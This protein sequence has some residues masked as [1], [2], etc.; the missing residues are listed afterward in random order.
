ML[1][2]LRRA[3]VV[4]WQPPHLPCRVAL[5]ATAATVADHPE[6]DNQLGWDAVANDLRIISLPGDH[7]GLLATDER[8]ENI[9]RAVADAW[10]GV[11]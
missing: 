9:A 3:M 5:L 11:S 10:P 6:S 2:A 1:T 8:R 4:D 7:S